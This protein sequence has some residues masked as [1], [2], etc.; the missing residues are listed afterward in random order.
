MCS[1]VF[2]IPITFELDIVWADINL[3][4]QGYRH[5]LNTSDMSFPYVP[6]DIHHVENKE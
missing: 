5:R 2:C 3:Q 4:L 6:L 1:L